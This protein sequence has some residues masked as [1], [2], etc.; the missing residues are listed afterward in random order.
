MMPTNKLPCFLQ[1]R[2]DLTSMSEPKTQKQNIKEDEIVTYIKNYFTE[3]TKLDPETSKLITDQ[4]VSIY[5]NFPAL[6]HQNSF[7]ATIRLYG[8]NIP[9]N[10]RSVRGNN[11]QTDPEFINADSGKK[12]TE[13][14]KNTFLESF[15]GH[16]S[17][18]TTKTKIYSSVLT[19]IS[20][21]K[22]QIPEAAKKEDKTNTNTKPTEEAKQ[23]KKFLKEIKNSDFVVE[24]IKEEEII[25]FIVR[26]GRANSEKLTVNVGQVVKA[27]PDP[28]GVPA[29][30]SQAN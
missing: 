5:K 18:H 22:E 25:D 11:S 7:S 23:A 4:I 26:F 21:F 24:S 3:P 1:E 13:E 30:P 14:E 10:V 6:L 15:E 16:K 17:I 29:N 20:N 8:Y 12:M 19:V 27:V 2:I 28:D 9:L